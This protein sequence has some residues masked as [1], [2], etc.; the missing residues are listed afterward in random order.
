MDRSGVIANLHRCR[1]VGRRCAR[2][3]QTKPTS[4]CVSALNQEHFK[5]AVAG[6]A[7]FVLAIVLISSQ[8][9]MRRTIPGLRTFTSEMPGIYTPKS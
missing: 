3:R 7:N 2:K 4:V 8:C 9:Q 1:P 6:H 5:P